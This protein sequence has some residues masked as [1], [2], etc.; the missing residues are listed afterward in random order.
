MYV[1][2]GAVTIQ[3]ANTTFGSLFSFSAGPSIHVEELKSSSV[4]IMI[5]D[6]QFNTVYAFEGE[7]IQ[8]L[9]HMDNLYL[10]I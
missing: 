9:L 8:I 5:S 10:Q 3:I 6:C 2:S 4:V 1:P 7:I